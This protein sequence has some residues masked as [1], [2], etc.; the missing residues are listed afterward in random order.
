MRLRMGLVATLLSVFSTVV[1]AQ[2]VPRGAN[3][4]RN[5][6]S[7]VTV[8]P[9]TYGTQSLIYLSISY[10]EFHPINSNTSY[11]LGIFHQC[12]RVQFLVGARSPSFRRPRQRGQAPFLR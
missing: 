9:Y 11:V 10:S 2:D 5:V 6:D 1:S 7:D 12:H 8:E 4:N 3:P